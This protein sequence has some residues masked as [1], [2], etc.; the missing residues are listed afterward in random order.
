MQQKELL[1]LVIAELNR[2]REIVANVNSIGLKGY[3]PKLSKGQKVLL[4]ELVE[5]IR[6]S[7]LTVPSIGELQGSA[8]KNKDSV[9]ELV[10]LAAENG[11]LVKVSDELFFHAEVLDQTKSQLSAAIEQS[12]GLTMSEIRQIL[13][14]SRKY[15]VPICEYLDRIGFT[16]RDGDKRKLASTQTQKQNAV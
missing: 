7:E 16:Y 14:T 6:V 5:K 9:L 13:S 15:A 11:D 10:E 4:E 12:N 1:N 8:K 2:R 3:G